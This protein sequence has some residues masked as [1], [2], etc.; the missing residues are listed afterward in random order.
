MRILITLTTVALCGCA[1]VNRPPPVRLYDSAV[2]SVR[3]DGVITVP[4]DLSKEFI[5]T[6]R[7]RAAAMSLSELSTQSDLNSVGQ[8]GPRTMR[9]RQEITAIAISQN[10]T[11]S[12]SFISGNVS[13][14]AKQDISITTSLRIEDC[15][16]GRLVHSYDY[17]S[18]G[19][20]PAQILSTL[21][22]YNIYLAD[23]YKHKR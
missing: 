20:N 2:L 16:D 4:T 6:I 11:A 5:E 19:T 9:V 22:S 8:C 3:S 17:T 1:A 18:N 7:A 15:S 23:Y 12:R 13:S 21:V 14:D 10:V